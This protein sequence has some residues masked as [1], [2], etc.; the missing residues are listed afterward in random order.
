MCGNSLVATVLSFPLVVPSLLPPLVV[1]PLIEPP[2]FVPPFVVPPLLESLFVLSWLSVWFVVIPSTL[3]FIVFP[4]IIGQDNFASFPEASL[5][6]PPLKLT[7]ANCP[8]SL[9]CIL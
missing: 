3:A 6:F 9:S 1:P 8:L 7:V 4:L 5:I 2:L